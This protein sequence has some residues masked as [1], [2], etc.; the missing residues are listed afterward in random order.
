MTPG[1]RTPPDRW[2]RLPV[3]RVAKN[4]TTKATE[5]TNPVALEHVEPWTGR[6]IP[7]ESTFDADGV[8]FKTGD[9]LFGKLRPYLA[10]VLVAVEPGE[11]VGDFI[12]MRPGVNTVEPRYIGYCLRIPAVID[13]LTASS[14]GSK[15]PRTSW[16][17]LSQTL[18]SVPPLDEQRRIA[19]FLDYETVRIDELIGD[20]KALR[21]RLLERRHATTVAA[22]SG[23][24]LFKRLGPSDLPWLELQADSWPTMR[25]R[26]VAKLGSGHTP[27]RSRPEYWEDCTIPWITTGEVSQI[28]EDRPEYLLDTR[29]RVSELGVRNSAAV[30]HPAGTVVLSRTASAGFSAIMGLDMATSQDFVTWTCG[31]RLRP[32][33]L[34]L[35][36]RA[37]RPDLLG[38]LA[39]GSTHKTI[40]FPD[41]ESLA[42][43]VP[44]VDEQDAAVD[45]AW[46]HLRDIDGMLD[47]LDDSTALLHER[48][49]ALIAAAVT[50]QI[51]VRTWT[52]PNDWFTPEA[53]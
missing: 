13:A 6:L 34:L 27:S 47:A 19:A 7:N 3:K 39:M 9:V 8:A 36:L 14:Y 22:V 12:V 46:A 18:V 51:D 42:I 33:F 29:E 40:Y 11:A 10:K 5:S 21:A 2:T 28:R 17:E 44:P 32:R 53:A 37:M 50:G 38:R 15:M 26:F 20:Q 4:V 41:V 16:E 49:S 25:I 48:R 24:L 52:P 1:Q 30:V 31:P 43:P 35:C 45:A 23:E